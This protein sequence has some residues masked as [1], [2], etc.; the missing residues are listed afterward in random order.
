MRRAFQLLSQQAAPQFERCVK[1][2]ACTART[3]ASSAT[4]H[5]RKYDRSAFG[6]GSAVAFGSGE[7]FAKFFYRRAAVFGFGGVVFYYTNLESVP[8]TNRRRLILF[9]SSWEGMLGDIAVKQVVG[10]GAI[11]Y[12]DDHPRTRMVKEVVSALSEQVHKLDFL[13]SHLKNIDWRVTVV[14]SNTVNAMAAP[15]GRIIVY[16]GIMDLLTRRDELAAVIA[17]EMAHVLARHSAEAMT[18]ALVTLPLRVGA[19]L[20]LESG[21]GVFDAMHNVLVALPASRA[22]EG[23]A[24]TIGMQLAARACYKPAGMISMLSKLENME[25]RMRAEKK[26]AF[27]RT[28]PLTS[29]RIEAARRQ[30]PQAQ[31]IM[32]VSECNAFS[33]VFDWAMAG[34]AD[35]T[36]YNT[37]DSL[38]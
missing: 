2:T 5:A 24:D 15:G 30:I 20:A 17:H 25:G 32:D 35:S 14:E 11:T 31:Q 37:D 12:P 34:S 33:V 28:H 26:P 13:P 9:P 22:A 18:A 3:F 4:A 7:E 6:Q 23:E 29:E 8:V 27:M 19:A 21:S 38:R 1:G 36:V 10:Q 16:T